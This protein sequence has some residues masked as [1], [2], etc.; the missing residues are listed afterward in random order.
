ME[1]NQSG[2]Y[3]SNPKRND[4]L[5]NPDVFQP[6]Y[7]LS[8]AL[9]DIPIKPKL[10]KYK[11]DSTRSYKY[12]MSSVEL[13]HEHIINTD[14]DMGMKVDL[15]DRDIYLPFPKPF[16]G[17]GSS[18]KNFTGNQAYGG[19]SSALKQEQ[20]LT[21]NIQKELQEL[22]LLKQTCLDEKDKFLL[23]DRNTFEIEESSRPVQKQ[24]KRIKL[25]VRYE[26][27]DKV[28]KWGVDIRN[29]IAVRQ[30]EAEELPENDSVFTLARDKH[31]K[32]QAVQ[33]INKRFK[34]S[35]DIQVGVSKGLDHPE[36][37]ATQVIDFIPYMQQIPNKYELVICDDNLDNELSRK[38]EVNDFLLH[39]YIDK[40]D[41]NHKKYAL[42][43]HHDS[44][45]IPDELKES[46]LGKRHKSTV[47]NTE[48]EKA[49]L[50]THV[51]DFIYTLQ[52][53]EEQMNDY[54]VMLPKQMTNGGQV[55][56]SVHASLTNSVRFIQ[57]CNKIGLLKKKR[58][59][60]KDQREMQ[61]DE[62][63]GV[64]TLSGLSQP[65][66]SNDSESI[67]IAGR[68]YTQ[69][70]VQQINQQFKANR[71][72]FQLIQGIASVFKD[73]NELRDNEKLEAQGLKELVKMSALKWQKAQ[74]RRN[75]M[76]EDDDLSDEGDNENGDQA[77]QSHDEDNDEIVQNQPRTKRLTK[78]RD[79]QSKVE[80]NN[81]VGFED[82]GDYDE[83]QENDDD[84]F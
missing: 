31:K 71:S 65:S 21:Q 66:Q 35:R 49:I 69:Q 61:V 41:V 5:Q 68:G 44:E 23:S 50:L 78:Q 26:L 17:P 77:N 83:E 18:N 13:N 8:Y 16:G 45:V 73:K 52:N 32:E 38:A 84:I 29:P 48:L 81:V 37:V 10:Y 82:M 51:R 56:T 25:P 6:P 72:D 60:R 2:Q 40:E 75:T 28:N 42:F 9:P 11:M 20:D 70:E 55:D 46:I 59:Q 62:V 47:T 33:Q 7:K 15:I 64:P 53:T 14:W 79:V 12:E 30:L 57:I 24:E 39:H 74:K 19:S 22:D 80:I 54:L 1:Q 63:N 36:I 4:L 27:I 3:R 34:A 67:V 43:K 76:N 58:H